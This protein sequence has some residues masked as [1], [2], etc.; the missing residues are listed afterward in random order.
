MVADERWSSVQH[1]GQVGCRVTG[2]NL[3]RRV[4]L[5][6]DRARELAL[7][8]CDG[9]LGGPC[10]GKKMGAGWAG[11]GIWPMGD[12]E[13]RNTFSYFFKSFIDCKLI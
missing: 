10:V 13:K 2:S 1:G 12:I 5:K 7:M 9:E 8:G 11:L 3:G 6:G 4:G